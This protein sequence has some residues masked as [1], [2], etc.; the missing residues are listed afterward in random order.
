M[1]EDIAKNIK[2]QL[3]S[4]MTTLYEQF[5]KSGPLMK[6]EPTAAQILKSKDLLRADKVRA[7]NLAKNVEPTPAQMNAINDAVEN[8]VNYFLRKESVDE[9]NVQNLKNEAG[10]VIN[11]PTRA[12]IENVV[13]FPDTYQQN[14][15]IIYET[16]TVLMFGQRSRDRDSFIVNEINQ[17]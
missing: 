3:G 5:E 9:I 4:Y 10:D 13:V 16:A 11:N 8:E 14:E 12:E 17:I 15:A 1:P 6:Y 2:G 7:L